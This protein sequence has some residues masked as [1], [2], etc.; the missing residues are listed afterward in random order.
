MYLGYLQL[1]KYDSDSGADGTDPDAATPR[2]FALVDSELEILP[3]ADVRRHG[4]A[5][6]AAAGDVHGQRGTR[7]GIGRHLDAHELR[8]AGGR[9]PRRRVGRG[10]RR[11]RR[12]RRVAAVLELEGRPRVYTL[13]HRHA[14]GL[15]CVAA[16]GRGDGVRVG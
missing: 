15:A 13:G 1:T 7:A 2:A 6:R 8:A 14:H 11:P 3:S 5:V 10:P 9:R 16:M 4:H 12:R